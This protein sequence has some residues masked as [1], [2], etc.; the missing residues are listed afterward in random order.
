MYDQ[1]PEEIEYA[2][3]TVIADNASRDGF[4]E[5]VA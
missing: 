5:E 1:Y 3:F 4:S 2:G